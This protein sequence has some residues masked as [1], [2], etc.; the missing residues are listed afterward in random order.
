VFSRDV[1]IGILAAALA[2]VFAAA[3]LLRAGPL[4]RPPASA[5]PS[6]AAAP[7][8]VPSTPAAA[9]VDVVSGA[10]ASA[11]LDDDADDP[12]A[13]EPVYEPAVAT[14]DVLVVD[15][16]DRP[17]AG[18]P[19]V[20]VSERDGT[21]LAPLRV[22]KKDGRARFPIDLV[23]EREGRVVV[24]A[25]AVPGFAAHA[26][27]ATSLD[28]ATET[29]LRVRSGATAR[30]RL[31]EEDGALAAGGRVRKAVFADPPPETGDFGASLSV[32]FRDATPRSFRDGVDL[33][34]HGFVQGETAALLATHVGFET[35]LTEIAVP[36]PAPSP[37]GVD[38]RLGARLS[39]VVFEAA[40]ADFLDDPATRFGCRGASD[41]EVLA[42]PGVDA[43][44]TQKSRR[45]RRDVRPG[46]PR[47]LRIEAYRDGALIAAGEFEVPALNP[48]ET[49]DAGV[50]RLEPTGVVLSGTIVDQD[51]APIVGAVVE[52]TARGGFSAATSTDA[53]GRF[54]VR[55]AAGAGPYHVSVHAGGRVSH[56]VADVDE[57]ARPLR[58]ALELA[59]GVEGRVFAPE[60]VE[61]A[62]LRVRALRAGRSP[63]ATTPAA[64]GSFRFGG[65]PQGVYVVVVDG[66]GVDPL[67]VSDVVVTPPDVTR[68]DRLARLTPGASAAGGMP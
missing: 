29:R 15:E 30:I 3:W 13:P 51:G 44:P 58:V 59:G 20:V 19:V 36:D 16:Q 55:G 34:L 33:L 46:E 24:A 42:A 37:F 63:A 50:V 52:C 65:L 53:L 45:F 40:A 6:V 62:A 43:G 17:L 22:A 64:D 9:P 39:G 21:L 38:L 28:R 14:L 10:A 56:V 68:D 11:P 2:G 35:T 12:E 5:G 48:G 31:T 67:R 26:V 41:G 60:G 27:V 1:K 57:G 25:R 32:A 7:D 49:F 61:V 47:R 8:S 4:L 54:A 23:F 66:P 18:V